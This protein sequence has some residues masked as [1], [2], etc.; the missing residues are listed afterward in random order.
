LF[1]QQA[2]ERSEA[3]KLVDSQKDSQDAISNP[4]EALGHLEP[5]AKRRRGNRLEIPGILPAEFLTDSEDDE[6]ELD[7]SSAVTKKRKTKHNKADKPVPDARVGAIVY[8]IPQV[9][10]KDLPP[11]SNK[12]SKTAK[13][14]L[15]TRGRMAVKARKQHGFLLK[16]RVTRRP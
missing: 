9:S 5:V 6:I 14:A 16:H 10:Q 11:K 2:K 7:S 4:E 1:K 13:K 15:L 3:Q 8:R 12:S